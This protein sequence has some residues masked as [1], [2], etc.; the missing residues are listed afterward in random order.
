MQRDVGTAV[1]RATAIV[2][3]PVPMHA[4]RARAGNRAVRRARRAP[5]PLG[6]ITA[7]VLIGVLALVVIDRAFLAPPAPVSS[8]APSPSPTIT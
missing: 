1:Y 5:V 7:M 4:I 8:R 6:V 3:P 2:A